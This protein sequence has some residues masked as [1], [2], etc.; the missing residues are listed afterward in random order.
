M[1]KFKRTRSAQDLTRDNKN[2]NNNCKASTSPE[3]KE[4]LKSLNEAERKVRGAILIASMTSQVILL[5]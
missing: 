5:P 4:C 1:L 2:S 3:P